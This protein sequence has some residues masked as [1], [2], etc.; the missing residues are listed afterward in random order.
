VTNVVTGT[1][2]YVY[3]YELTGIR[4][5]E[6]TAYTTNPLNQY[7][8]ISNPAYDLNGHQKSAKP[9]AE[10]PGDR[11]FEAARTRGARSRI[12]R[13]SGNCHRMT[14]ACS[15]GVLLVSNVYDHQSR[16]IRKEV[17][18]WDSQST[19][20]SLQSTAAFL[21]DDW[22]VIREVRGQSSA[23]STNYYTWGVDLSGSLQGVPLR[24]GYGGQAGGVG[25]LL[26]VT[27]VS[28]ATGT[29]A[30]C[31]P[32]YDANGNVTDYLDANGNNVA[33]REYSAFGETVVQTGPLV[34]SFTYWWSTKPWCP[35]TGLSEYQLRAYSP[36]LGRWMSRDPIGE[37]IIGSANL[38]EFV[39]NSPVA[40][41]DI[42]GLFGS[43]QTAAGGAWI[44][45]YR[46]VGSPHPKTHMRRTERIRMYVPKGHSD[47]PEYAEFDYV[48]QD[49]GLTNPLWN[50]ASHF[51]S[52]GKTENELVGIF[53]TCKKEAFERSMHKGQ[54]NFSHYEKDY[55][56]DPFNFTEKDWGFGH[57]P[58]SVVG[59]NPDD[60]PVAW[61]KANA[62]TS[63]QLEEWH[64]N[65]VK[66][67]GVWKHR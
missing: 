22:N 12:R 5:G 42:L 62:W 27:T 17:Y 48:K 9:K 35:V 21:W 55:R 10:P 54:D 8:A 3:A 31:Y 52:L 47:F 65:C 26:A 19:A 41:C 39:L 4:N 23:V 64:K 1:H 6:A 28:Q 46:S 50:P 58:D 25:G 7:T 44:W 30:S 34:D 57:G 59:I 53:Q 16:R 49:T 15:N 18:A 67:G 2:E 66:C 33:H 45:V 20:Y 56:W 38:Y 32:V 36:E 13:H 24:Q 61:E 51:Q 14:S 29:F 37:K 40:D 63:L 43:G 11:D 60:D